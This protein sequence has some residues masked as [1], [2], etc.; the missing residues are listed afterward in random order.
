MTKITNSKVRFYLAILSIFAVSAAWAQDEEAAGYE[1]LNEL[2]TRAGMIPFLQNDN[3]QTAAANHAQ[4]LV[5]NSTSSLRYGGHFENPGDPYFTGNQAS[6]RT[7]AADYLSTVVSENV[8]TGQSDVFASIDDLFSA[9]YHRFG[10]LSFS[11]D[12]VGLGFVKD[13][14]IDYSAYTYNMGN[15]GLNDLCRG[16]S[17]TSTGNFFLNLCSHDSDFRISGTDK[18]AAEEQIEGQNPF[19]VTWPDQGDTDVPPAFFEESPDPLPDYSV[20]GYPISLQFNPM[21]Y[22]D[23]SVTSFRIFEDSSNREISNTR[24]LD[25]NT[26]PNMKFSGLEFALFPLERLDWQ[27]VYRVEVKYD[28]NLESDSLMW[29]FATRNPG[30]P[31]FEYAGDGTTVEIPINAANDFI[32]YVPPDQ[33]YPTIQNIGAS[34]PAGLS[35]D[36]NF[37]DG[38]TLSVR[39]VG[40]IGQQA[41]FEMVGRS[42]SLRIGNQAEIP[43]VPEIDLTED[44]VS[45]GGNEAVASFNESTSILSIPLLVVDGELQVGVNLRLI[46]GNALTFVVNDVIAADETASDEALFTSSSLELTIPKLSALGASFSVTMKLVDAENLLFQITTAEVLAEQP[47]SQL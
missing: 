12:E 21:V 41:D 9:I 40:S 2:R 27:T 35:V 32:F 6:D 46:D 44:G 45:G 34:F 28:S 14:V 16:S 4:Y 18:N 43:V 5:G 22:T 36:V 29:K 11:M 30:A 25:R 37:I 20:S 47:Q 26:D 39:M 31:L 1:Y 10:F 23:V 17:F 7:G 13:S 38:N 42:F 24:L 8:S 15:T 3:L 33:N 19:L